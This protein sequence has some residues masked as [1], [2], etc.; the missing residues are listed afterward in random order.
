MRLDQRL[1][2]QSDFNRVRNAS[3]SEKRFDQPRTP[4]DMSMVLASLM[5]R[6]RAAQ[7][8]G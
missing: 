2:S 5:R 3:S 7:A 4:R 1:E 6:A 8:V